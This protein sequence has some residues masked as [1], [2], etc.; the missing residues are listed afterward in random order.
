MDV[1]LVLKA[2]NSQYINK[3]KE[4]QTAT[5]KLHDTNEKGQKTN[6]GLIEREIKMQE[7]LSQRA[8]KAKEIGSLK[9]YN[10][11]LDDS[12][13]RLDSLHKAGLDVEKQGD[14]MI[15]SIGKWALGLGVVTTAISLLKN[16]LLQTQQ[17]ILLFNQAGAAMNQ[18]LYN[19]VSGVSDWNSGVA[20]SIRLAKQMEELT[21]K[22]RIEMLEAKK[23]MREY[24]ELY[25][26]GT[27]ATISSTE[28]IKKLTE[29][30][31]KY[32]AAINI[33][34]ASTKE[35]LALAIDAWKLQ[36][37]NDAAQ[38]KAI[39][40]VGKIQDLEGQINQGTRRLTRQITGEIQENHNKKLSLWHKEIE[41]QNKINEEKW[42]LE[43]EA[44]DA[45]RKNH[46]DIVQLYK[47]KW[48]QIVNEEIAGNELKS[49]VWKLF[50][51]KEKDLTLQQ[52]KTIAE[53]I[54][55]G[56]EA[57]EE[58]DIKTGKKSTSIWELIGIDPDSEKGREQV[59]VI[60]DASSTVIRIIDEVYAKRVEDA[61]RRRE[62]L[63]TQISEVQAEV[64]TEV[65]LYKAGYASNVKAKQKELADLKK[66]RDTA[67]VQEKE[68]VKQQQSIE[69]TSQAISLASSVA[70]ILKAFT[71]M[72]PIGIILAGAA[73]GAI[74]KI[75]GDAKAKVK[76]SVGFAKGGYT[77]DSRG[78]RD[79]TGEEVAGTVHKKEFVVRRGP[80]SKFR[81]VLEA[82][83]R[84][85]KKMILHTFNKLSPELL[86]GTTVNN[87]IVENEGPNKRLDQVTSEIRKLNS[88][89]TNESFQ[90]FD[91]VQVIRKGNSV[92][93]IRE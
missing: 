50:G 19:I 92:R 89:M 20:E 68:A 31:G 91:R 9:Q 66:Q 67:L 78:Y 90:R 17:G 24:N 83:N 34:I 64:E 43:D 47:D 52:N 81:E 38:A 13:K 12:K 86:G 22:D 80:A 46:A 61:Q 74:F 49:K 25:T 27:D 35:Q 71:K 26:E 41:E 45:I 44:E 16:A 69:R 18:V 40:L 58:Y 82:I 11:L 3:I 4:A 76:E 21:R 53:A 65:E 60:K 1:T 88:K 2:D 63:D 15:Q 28:R 23:L 37:T 14:S 72:G 29:A 30:K 5:Q 70:N 85:D 57:A 77:G 6:L 54:V 79:D 33:E 10:Q 75:W 62:L 8:N 73:I 87:V 7:Q 39:E 51:L 55:K 48:E 56:H 36:P 32:I 59:E 42:R 93:T 84:D